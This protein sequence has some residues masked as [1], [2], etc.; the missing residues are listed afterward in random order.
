MV[1]R[2]KR[3][4]AVEIIPKGYGEAELITKLTL[5]AFVTEDAISA[6]E[7]TFR[8]T[9]FTHTPLDITKAGK[10]LFTVIF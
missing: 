2:R 4:T 7:Q 3:H 6:Y 1:C 10:L 9:L 8:Q 5:I